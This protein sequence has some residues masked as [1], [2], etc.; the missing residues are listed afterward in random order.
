MKRK[1]I[2]FIMLLSSCMYNV[3][4]SS[5]SPVRD[6]PMDTWRQLSPIQQQIKLLAQQIDQLPKN[7]LSLEADLNSLK[8]A[9]HAQLN[10][11]DPNFEYSKA[12]STFANLADFQNHLTGITAQLRSNQSTAG[13]MLTIFKLRTPLAQGPVVVAAAKPAAPTS[14]I[15]K[16]SLVRRLGN[17]ISGL[18]VT[19][20]VS[21]ENALRSSSSNIVIE[22][23]LY[24]R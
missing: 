3:H 8:S 16:P 23:P 15:V 6:I 7:Y 10:F 21:A 13:R 22:N 11:L 17:F 5:V 20:T 24:Y 14:T 2:A 4:G 19:P 1:K 12:E 18:K 9:L